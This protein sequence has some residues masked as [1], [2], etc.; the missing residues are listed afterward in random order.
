MVKTSES[1][2]KFGK[3]M[4]TSFAFGSHAL[5]AF[6]ADWARLCGSYT[7]PIT[8]MIDQMLRDTYAIMQDMADNIDDRGAAAVQLGVKNAD[9]LESIAVAMKKVDPNIDP[10]NDPRYQ[11]AVLDAQDAVFKLTKGE[12]I[13]E[14]EVDVDA[15]LETV[16]SAP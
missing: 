12:R 2:E 14:V 8:S 6:I 3:A 4:A 9:L 15:I 13:V 16:D 11:Q 5:T 7:D 1:V 10:E